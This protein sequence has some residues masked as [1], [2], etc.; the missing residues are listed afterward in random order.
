[1]KCLYFFAIAIFITAANQAVAQNTTSAKQD[2]QIFTAVESAPEYPGGINKFYEHITKNLKY[3]EV[4]RLLGI[5]GKVFVQFIIEKDGSVGE[6]KPVRGIGAGC[7]AEAVRV[8]E[9]SEKWKPAIQNS[10]PVRVL[11]TIP[12][13]F[14]FQK[15]PKPEK[16]GI[17]SLERSRFGFVIELK[18]KYYTLSE[19]RDAN[20]DTLKSAQI[21][22][23][24]PFVDDKYK[25]PE[26]EFVYLV[27]LKDQQ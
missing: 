26:K 13:S 11:Y 3:P 24:E 15:T 8:L 5:T 4:A 10:R 22:D 2:D 9:S 12:I 23:A 1:M 19:F 16:I 18:D 14:D 25:M 7:D 17:Q 6:V 21:I 27:R 20:G